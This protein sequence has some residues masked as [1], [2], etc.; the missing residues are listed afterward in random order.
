MITLN[1]CFRGNDNSTEKRRIAV[2]NRYPHELYNQLPLDNDVM[3]LKLAVSTLF[4]FINEKSTI[5]RKKTGNGVIP[6]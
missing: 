5:F 1:N 6:T 2:V 3:L 4:L